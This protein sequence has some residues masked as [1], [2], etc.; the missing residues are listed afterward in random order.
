[1]QQVC[2]IPRAREVGQGWISSLIFSIFAVLKCF[3]IVYRCQPDVILINGPG[4]CVPVVIVSRILSR[5]ALCPMAKIIFIE[6]ICRVKSL[7]LSAR[8]LWYVVDDIIVQWP[9]LMDTNHGVK[10]IGKFL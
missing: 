10:F 7:S 1:M 9:E 4:T 2:Q 6:S 5:V 8:I 3:P